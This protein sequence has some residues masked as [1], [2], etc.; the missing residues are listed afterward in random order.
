LVVKGHLAGRLLQRRS[1]AEGNG[2]Q[3]IQAPNLLLLPLLPLLPPG[4]PVALIE[5]FRK[6]RK[7]ARVLYALCPI[8]MADQNEYRNSA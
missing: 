8:D 1:A 3:T 5:L 4:L 2:D 7:I 6:R